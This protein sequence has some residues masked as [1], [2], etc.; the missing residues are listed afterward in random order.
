VQEGC[1]K[2]LVSDYFNLHEKLVSAQQRGIAIDGKYSKL[3]R[4]YMDFRI[5]GYCNE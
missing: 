1:K 3:K 5:S 2:I 4:W